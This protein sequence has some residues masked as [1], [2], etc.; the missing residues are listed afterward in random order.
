MSAATTSRFIL[1]MAIGLALSACSDETADTTQGE[2]STTTAP[3]S[4]TV[5]GESPLVGQWERAEST[6]TS[7]DGMII[8][9]QADGTTAVILTV[10]EN[11]Y[12]FAAGDEKWSDIESSG[13]LE[14]TFQDLVREEGSGATSHVEGI[15]TVSEDGS[16]L[17]MTFP[18]TGTTQEWVRVDGS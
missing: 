6:F 1:L 8:E 15:I 13:D 12:Q 10:P 7:L 4:T 3:A 5:A 2:D 14:Y 9:V 11:E 16:T 18:T 17:V